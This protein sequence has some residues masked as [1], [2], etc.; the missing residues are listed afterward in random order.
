MP[1]LTLLEVECEAV[2]TAGGSG[3]GRHGS[4]VRVEAYSCLE[5]RVVTSG[6]VTGIKEEMVDFG[7]PWGS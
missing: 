6:T 5:E 3:V 4:G 2:L 7:G 1:D